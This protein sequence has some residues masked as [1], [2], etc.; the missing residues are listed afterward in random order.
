VRYS[1]VN[2]HKVY[3]SI[4]YYFLS[5]FAYYEME[6]FNQGLNL[7]T[8]KEMFFFSVWETLFLLSMAM[9]YFYSWQTYSNNDHVP[10]DDM[11]FEGSKSQPK[12]ECTPVSFK[13][14]FWFSRV[15]IWSA[16]SNLFLS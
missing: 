7:K 1:R 10:E 2:K 11:E 12:V 8:S 16:I 15:A 4:F 3:F 6:C 13:E 14:A 9:S 5:L